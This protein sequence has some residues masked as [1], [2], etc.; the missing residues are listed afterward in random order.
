[1]IFFEFDRSGS[2]PT[3]LFQTFVSGKSGQLGAAGSGT[4]AAP[5]AAART[6]AAMETATSLTFSFSA[7]PRGGQSLA[8][9]KSV[10][11]SR[12]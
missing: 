6:S 11:G 9:Q 12:T 2:L 1:M 3:G 4:G 5:A 7:F 10:R 8:R